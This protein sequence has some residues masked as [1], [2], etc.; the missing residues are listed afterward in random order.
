MKMIIVLRE[1]IIQEIKSS[2]AIP[3]LEIDI[4]DRTYRDHVC[5]EDDDNDAVLEQEL[6]D[7]AVTLY[8]EP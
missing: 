7:L 4:L 2:E 1:G 3:D 8:P 6:D 5:E